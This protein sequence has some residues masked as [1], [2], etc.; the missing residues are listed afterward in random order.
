MRKRSFPD[1]WQQACLNLN[2]T[3]WTW[4]SKQ[5]RSNRAS[6]YPSVYEPSILLRTVCLAQVPSRSVLQEQLFAMSLKVH[7]CAALPELFASATDS[8]SNLTEQ[9]E[10]VS[11]LIR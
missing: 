3:T 6:F 7:L 8:E 5:E 2:F 9:P 4:P 11:T 10:V 1:N